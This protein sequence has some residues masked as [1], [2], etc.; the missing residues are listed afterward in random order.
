MRFLFLFICI[1]VLLGPLQ[2]QEPSSWGEPSGDYLLTGATI[3]VAPGRVIRGGDL[4]VKDGRV[5]AVGSDLPRNPSS[6]V[7]DVSGAEIHAGF[8]DPYVAGSKVGFP[9]SEATPVSG[10]HPKIHDDFEVSHHLDLKED[11]LKKFR[12][13]GFV[14]VNVVPEKG[15]FRGQGALYRCGT[16]EN[17]ARL[18]VEPS[19]FSVVGF[20]EGGWGE[21][22]GENYPLS[23]MGNTA[24]IRQTFLDTD[25]YHS[26]TPNE[27]IPEYQGSLESLAKVTSGRRRLVVEGQD[28]LDVL[29]LFSLLSELEIPKAAVVLSGEEWMKLAWL[30]PGY[31]TI[32]PLDFPDN[33]K[34]GGVVPKSA[35][36]LDLLRRWYFAPANPGWLNKRGFRFSLTTHRLKEPG[37]FRK[38]LREAVAGGLS[39]QAALAALTTTPARLLGVSGDYG[40]LEPG[41]SASFVVR[42]GSVFD[43]ESTVRE[44]WIDGKRFPG[45]QAIAKGEA[46]EPDKAEIRDFVESASYTK[47]PELFQPPYAPSAV[48]VEGATIWKPSGPEQGSLTVS[49]GKISGFTGAAGHRITGENLHVTPGIVDAHS[50]TAI[51]GMVNEPGA[52]I[53]AMVRM[54]DVIDPFDHNIYLQLASGVTAVNILHGSAN[55]IGGQSITCKWRLGELPERLIMEGAPE[56]IKFA[57]GENP[58]QSNWGDE[59]NTRYPQSRMGVVELIRG[60]FVSARNYQQ[61]KS[62]GKSPKPDLVL[63][64]LVEVLEGKRIVHCHSYRQDEILALIRA[65]EEVGFTVNVF[66]HVLEGYK[67]AK[68]IAA[69]GGSASTFADWWAYK[70]EVDDAIPYNAALMKQAGVLV[71]VNSDSNDL[72]RRLNTE[73]AKSMRYGGLTPN[74]CLQMI[75]KNPAEQLG[76]SS[77]VGTL[78]MGKDGDFVVWQGDPMT[79]DAVVLETWIDGKRYF[80]RSEEQDRV[81]RL[82]A[83]RERYL[84]ILEEQ[85]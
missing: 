3:T 85:K 83:E 46:A 26:E 17:D 5:V 80:K 28:Y 18:L 9:D 73:A 41:R 48:V 30:T 71:S 60:A 29:R 65:A 15:I 13:S 56:G 79:Q 70:V 8:I 31:D 50:H 67:V 34:T 1:I 20:E 6:Q 72:A 42:K 35:L 69:H 39:E 10:N 38:R 59:H 74:E 32:L 33:P 55:A 43:E 37:D 2:A 19:T 54:K 47:P 57:L 27:G 82:N 21:L 25:W 78:E 45:Y 63:E 61:L 75:T 62:E 49:G 64:A 84:E 14:L 53:T 40:T 66:Q 4:R 12:K 36:T 58:K 24:L 52:N 7:I 44:V 23:T 68:E 51:D 16:E 77:R 81:Q 22:K 11:A 76:V